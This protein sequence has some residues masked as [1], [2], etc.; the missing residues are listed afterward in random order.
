[1]MPTTYANI[2]REYDTMT[3]KDYELIA[4]GFHAASG[5]LPHNAVQDGVM[6]AALGVAERLGQ[7]NP[8]FNLNTFMWACGWKPVGDA[9]KPVWRIRED[10]A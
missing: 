3:R 2:Y 7:D 1:M 8:R 6:T 9:R 5:R 10:G 4:A